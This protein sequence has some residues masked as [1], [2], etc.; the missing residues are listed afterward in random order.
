MSL[1]VKDG[2]IESNFQNV[3]KRAPP[4]TFD[5]PVHSGWATLL[6]CRT[7]CAVQNARVQT[8]ECDADSEANLFAQR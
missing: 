8:L 1:V 7:R 4:T 3:A 2:D 5:R 6:S